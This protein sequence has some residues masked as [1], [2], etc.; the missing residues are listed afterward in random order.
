MIFKKFIQTLKNVVAELNNGMKIDQ[1]PVQKSLADI[2]ADYCDAIAQ[3]DFSYNMFAQNALMIAGKKMFETLQQVKWEECSNCK[4]SYICV[5]IGPKSHKC[6][7][8]SRNPRTFSQ[9]NDMISSIAPQCLS[10]LSPIE[11]SAIS[12]ICPTIAIYKK[13]S[14]SSSSKGHCISFFQDV[15]ELAKALP[16]LPADLPFLVIKN[17]NERLEDKMFHVRRNQLIDPF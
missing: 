7:R 9:E 14:L 13:G 2:R 1:S 11:K 10:T 12:I 17:P 5:P 3:D 15:N 16:R 6:Q 4:E 8:C